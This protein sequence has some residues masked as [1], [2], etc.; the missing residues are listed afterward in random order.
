MGKSVSTLLL[1][2]CRPFVSRLIVAAL[3]QL[4]IKVLSRILSNWPMLNGVELSLTE[5][6]GTNWVATVA[7]LPQ[8]CSVPAR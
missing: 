3:G 5:V 4:S 7:T 2:F 6:L 8:P 1:R